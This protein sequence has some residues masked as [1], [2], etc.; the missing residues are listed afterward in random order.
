MG[1][2]LSYEID[3]RAHL[4]V[5][6]GS[7]LRGLAGISELNSTLD[8]SI[9]EAAERDEYAVPVV[10]VR[11]LPASP[12]PRKIFCVGLNYDEHIAEAGREKP[13]YP[14]LF[15][16]FASNLIGPDD[17]IQLPF[18]SAQV[19][20]EGELA[21]II[22]NPGRR[23]RENAAMDHVL[24]F[25]VTNDITMRDY[26]YKTHQWWLQGKAWDRSTPLDAT[27]LTPSEVDLATAG[28]PDCC[29]RTDDAGIERGPSHLLH[30][31]LDRSHLDI[32]GTPVRGC[33]HDRHAGRGGLPPRPTSFSEGRRRSHRRN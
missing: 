20:Y 24:G 4:G 22:G 17:A 23:I 3:G 6:E 29:E 33:H 2:Y 13:T 28:D 5:I 12:H 31:P 16:K 1:K 26:Q 18:E 11:R 25:A 15:T 10:T 19:D 9:L 32:H 7:Q 8:L 14:V 30:P 21:V 27:I